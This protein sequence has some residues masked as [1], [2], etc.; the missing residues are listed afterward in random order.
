MMRTLENSSRRRARAGALRH[1]ALLGVAAAFL[2]AGT[3]LARPASAVVLDDDNVIKL[4]LKDGTYLQCYGVATATQGE[5]SHTYYYLPANLHLS[6]RADGVPEFL[7]LK[8]T[9]EARA[10]Q[11]GISGGLLHFLME[12]GLTPDQDAEAQKLLKEKDPKGVLLGAAPVDVPADGASFQI[13]SGTLSDEKMAGKLV[14]SGKAPLVEGGKAAAATRLS[15]EGAQLLAATFEKSRSITDL[16]VQCNYQYQ[17]LTPAAKGTI[18]F[19]WSRLQTA[20]DSLKAEYTHKQVGTTKTGGSFLFFD[21]SSYNPEYSNSYDEMHKQYEFLVEKQVVDIHFDE[22]VADERVAKIREAFFQYFLNSMTE[23]APQQ[24]A[25]APSDDEKQQTPDIKQGARYVYKKVSFT[26]A[27]QQKSKVISLNYRIA[28]KHDLPLVGN[29]ADWYNGVRDNPQCV[30]A[31]NLND[32][33]F[34]H[35]DINFIMDLD[36]KDMFE[37]ECN[38]VTVNV[39]KLRDSGN[40]FQDH[41]TIDSKYVKEKGINA[42]VTYAR[43]DDKNSDLY[44]YQAQWSFRGGRIYPPNP[45]WEKGSWEGVTLAAPI[46]PRT[47]EV[48]GD[49]DAMK[50]SDITRVTV[51]IHYPKF[52]QEMEENFS[53]S[54]VKNEPLIS[55]K[56]FMDR[57]AKGYVYR[58]IVDHKTEGKMATPWSPKVGDD[59]I[60][61]A[62]PKDMLTAPALKAEAKTAALD[63]ATSAKEKVLDK[64]SELLGGNKQ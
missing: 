5:K 1:A 62:V 46:S 55:K 9:T 6:K 43:G 36:A 41:I 50:A 38:Y 22:L 45:A 2:L 37:Q 40:P 61:A 28:I 3:L 56:I 47:I 26:S 4:S 32:P 19:N 21:W 27:F 64:F 24:A 39:R 57:D 31:V 15:P 12:W 8:F 52:G 17:T 18:T 25:Q 14:T 10:D 53:I 63:A 59:Y 44:E 34:Q 42:T 16:S 13:I 35:R 51:Q 33:F 30:S 23:P 7:F 11:G 49:L 20:Y 48:E 58:M 60:Y 54:P 29:M